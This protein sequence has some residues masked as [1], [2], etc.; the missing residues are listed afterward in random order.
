MFCV[1]ETSL[2]DNETISRSSMPNGY[3]SFSRGTISRKGGTTI[4]VKDSY[5]CIERDDLMVQSKEFES[6]WLEIKIKKGKNIVIGCIYRH[7]YYNNHQDYM[8]KT[9]TNLDKEKKK[10]I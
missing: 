6:I 7:P 4:F 2:T 3:E 5:D 8:H 9:L 1:T 10:C